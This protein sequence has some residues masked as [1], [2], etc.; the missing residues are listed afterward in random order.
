M[1]TNS[2]I[3]ARSAAASFV[4]LACVVGCSSS[5]S[6][7]PGPMSDGGADGA[8][9]NIDSGIDSGGAAPADVRGTYSGNI[10]NGPNTCPGDWTVGDSAKVTV[11]VSQ[12]GNASTVDVTGA[13]GIFLEVAVGAHTFNGTVTDSNLNASLLGTTQHSLG[14][15][16]YT[17]RADFS[18]TLT[19]DALQGTLTYSPQTNQN[20]DCASMSVNGCTRTQT[21]NGI[22]P[23]P[24]Q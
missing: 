2:T 5:S 11:K 17:W 23:P 24:G 18:A 6:S 19:G 4:F 20:G 22:R 21:F 13:S 7:G 12:T 9:A 1:L 10:V 16:N 15:C 14:A 3:L 8:Y